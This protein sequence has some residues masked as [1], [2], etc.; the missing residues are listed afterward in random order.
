MDRRAF[1]TT[2]AAGWAVDA[3]VPSPQK[4][5]GRVIGASHGVGHLLRDGGAPSPSSAGLPESAD[6][7]IVGGGVAG[8]SAAWR[9]APLGL[10]VRVLEL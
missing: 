8:L 5:G 4:I 6:V 1:L 9:L 3:L 7:V 10:D 2:L